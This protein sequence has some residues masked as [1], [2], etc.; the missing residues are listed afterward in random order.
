ML[1]TYYILA[2]ILV[3]VLAVLSLLAGNFNSA[4]QVSFSVA[5]LALVYALALWSVFTNTNDATL[6]MLS[7]HD[8]LRYKGE[9]Q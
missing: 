2:W 8:T 3:T 9:K 5:V 6:E 7:K 4:A 1:K